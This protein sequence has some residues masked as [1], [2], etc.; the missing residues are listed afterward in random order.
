MDSRAKKLRHILERSQRATDIVAFIV[1]E[2]DA[3]LEELHG[4]MAPIQERTQN[5]SNAHKNLSRCE[6]T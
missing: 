5:L 2:T 4:I 3:Q 6:K 1:R